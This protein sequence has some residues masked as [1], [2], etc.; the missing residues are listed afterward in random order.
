MLLIL[1]FSNGLTVFAETTSGM[2][3]RF[4]YESYRDEYRLDYWSYPSSVSSVYIHFTSPDGSTYDSN[5]DSSALTGIFYFTCTGTYDFYLKDANGINQSSIIG[6]STSSIVNGSCTSH[7]AGTIRNDLGVKA[8]ETGGGNYT[9]EWTPNGSSNYEIYKNGN[10]IGTTSSATA[11]VS[12]SGSYTVKASD[13]AESDINLNGGC[14]GCTLITE[15]LSCP[16]WQQYMGEWGK[17]IRDNVPP[18]P[19]W[20]MV[21]QKMKDAIVPAMGQE[22]VDRMPELSTILADELQSR[23]KAVTAPGPLPTF[24]PSVPTMTDLSSPV[25]TDLESNVPDF[26][27]DY[28]GDSKVTIPDPQAWQPDNTDKGYVKGTQDLSSPSYSKA[29]P[30]TQDK[31]YTAAPTTT[32]TSP[33]YSVTNQQSTAPAPAYQPPAAPAPDRTSEYTFPPIQSAPSYTTTGTAG[34]GS[35]PEYTT[36]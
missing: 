35:A 22:L 4:F 27:P 13:G 28:S 23:E 20:D 16:S 3:Q 26:T 1:F 8:T 11:T 30:T 5:Y 31:G 12:G 2:Q 19:D 14:N 33:S 6:L 21:A 25:T 15:M 34:T 17:T 24:S 36:K 7:A 10:M 9:L 18:A 32:V 29:E